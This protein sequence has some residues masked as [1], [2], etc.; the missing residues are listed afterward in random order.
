[1]K[2][3]T[4]RTF[5]LTTPELKEAILDWIYSRHSAEYHQTLMETDFEIEV[6]DNL[7]LIIPSR[8]FLEF[9]SGEKK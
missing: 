8:E 5:E 1:M 7:Y 6:C 2:V 9:D 3:T 4:S